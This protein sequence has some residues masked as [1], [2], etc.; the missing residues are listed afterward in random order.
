[1]RHQT[2]LIFCLLLTSLGITR[3]TFAAPPEVNRILRVMDFEERKL[4]NVEPL[5]MH[6]EKVVGP[7]L[8][9]Y[10]NGALSRDRHR[11]DD[12]SFKFDLNGG[13][14]IYRYDPHQLPIEVGVRYRVETYVQT[15]VLPNARARLTAYFCDVDMNPLLDTV[16][17]SELYAAKA[18]GEPWHLLDVELS[19]DNPKAAYLVIELALLQQGQY[20]PSTLGD[21]ALFAQDIH[22]SAWFDDLR[23][24]QVPEMTLQTS[25]TGNIFP[26]GKPMQIEAIVR[27]RYTDDLAAQLVLRDATGKIVYQRTGALDMNQAV[28]IAPMVKKLAIVLPQMPVGWYSA[29]IVLTSRG[30]FIGEHR[31][32]L[33]QLADAGRSP[34]P[35]PRFGVDATSLPFAGWSELPDLL[36]YLATGR[37]KIGVWTKEGDIQQ[38]DSEG[39]DLLLSRL[40]ENGITPT[41]CLID[42]PPLIARQLGRTG[43]DGLLNSDNAEVWRQPLSYLISRHADHLD[44]WQL[45]AD[46]SDMFVKQGQMRQVYS[47]VYD[48][49]SKLVQSPDLAM[50]WPAWY[51]LEG[52]LPATVA[53]SVPSS[54]LPSQLPLYMQ[55]ISKHEG[56]NLSLSLQL[57]DEKQYGRE[58]MIRDL[59]QRVVYALAADA[60]RIDVPLPFSVKTTNGKVIKQPN[61]LVLIERT[62]LTTL[63]GARFGGKVPID[64]NIE[65]FLFQ[66]GSQG[67]LVAWSRGEVAGSQNITVNL[68]PRARIMDLWGASTPL[69]QSGEGLVKL[70]IGTMPIFLTDI[71]AYAAQIRASVHF[72]QPL[73][74]SSFK[75]HIRKFMFTNPYPQ[76][77][78]GTLRLRGPQGWTINPPTFHFTLNPGETFSRDVM[79][80]FPYNSFAGV[81]TIDAEFDVQAERNIKFAVPV[82]LRLGLSDVG[83]QTLAIRDGKDV[84]V[85]QMISNYGDKP[86]DYTAFAVY[87]GQARQERLVTGLDPGRTTIKRYRFTNVK[88]VPGGVVRSGIKETFGE[89][90]LNEQVEIQ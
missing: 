90:I 4:G 66:K 55:D 74:E 83:I 15:T 85:Q 53:M 58:A 38:V 25:Q 6:W 49:F 54:V 64:E 39:F 16:T 24:S 69:L 50:P 1:M 68:G 52:E 65:A 89:R 10:V 8:P 9:H 61:E 33:I 43:W 71:D 80:E 17:H 7:D 3:A 75:P 67:I 48:C 56:H 62:L 76:A 82:Q 29:G 81:K 5:P 37:V 88:L 70:N 63:S 44:R 47:T 34:L 23:V 42:V 32:D 20:Q 60:Q 13:G 87:P 45:G 31:I 59:A 46:G 79:I 57:L 72:D 28:L 22:G 73:V 36:P 51:E 21:A 30:E 14:L 2:A 27:D 78:G 26:Q 11:S 18:E 84:F 35:D 41:A 86:I 19:S 40:H 77:I 12:Y